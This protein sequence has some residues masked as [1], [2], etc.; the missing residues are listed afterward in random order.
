M[1]E[2]GFDKFQHPGK[3]PVQKALDFS[4][5]LLEPVREFDRQEN[6]R[7]TGAGSFHGDAYCTVLLLK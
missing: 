5:L 3:F 6:F 4:E 1:E 2:I 7:C